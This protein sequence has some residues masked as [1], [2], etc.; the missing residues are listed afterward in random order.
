MQLEDRDMPS[1]LGGAEIFGL[2]WRL[3]AE[4]P[5]TNASPP[6]LLLF[7]LAS[8][9]DR[10]GGRPCGSRYSAV[11]WPTSS[12][13]PSSSPTTASTSSPTSTPPTPISAS[14]SLPGSRSSTAADASSASA[15]LTP[16]PGSASI[17]TSFSS[18]RGRS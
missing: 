9:I 17:L 1:I 11:W 13:A 10:C 6:P 8:S 16:T 3:D 12:S 18:P 15:S 2:G 5:S 14:P 7:R 4:P